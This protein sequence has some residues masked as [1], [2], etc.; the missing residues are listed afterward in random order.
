MSDIIVCILTV[1]I[2]YSTSNAGH[3]AGVDQVMIH[4]V[5][6][7]PKSQTLLVSLLSRREQL[8]NVFS[9][10]SGDIHLTIDCHHPWFLPV[11]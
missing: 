7:K 11:K 5:Q 3:S 9:S 1:I 2:Q 8:L 6:Y 10:Q 4:W